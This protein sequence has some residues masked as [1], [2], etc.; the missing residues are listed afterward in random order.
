MLKVKLVLY[1][2]CIVYRFG[3]TL[4][5]ILFKAEVRA[6]LC[7]SVLFNISDHVILCCVAFCFMLV[8]ANKLITITIISITE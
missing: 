2:E 6:I 3:F 8:V 7:L 5:S 1:C 4:I